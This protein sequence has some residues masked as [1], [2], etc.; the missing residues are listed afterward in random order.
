MQYPEIKRVQ[1]L[2]VH[3]LERTN[4]NTVQLVKHC[5]MLPSSHKYGIKPQMVR[6]PS[7]KRQHSTFSNTAIIILFY[8]VTR[9]AWKLYIIKIRGNNRVRK[10]S[11]GKSKRKLN[12]ENWRN[13]WYLYWTLKYQMER[14]SEYRNSHRNGRNALNPTSPCNNVINPRRRSQ[15]SW[16][17]DF[18]QTAHHNVLWPPVYPHHMQLLHH[19][20]G[21][22]TQFR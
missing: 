11:S 14:I 6:T 1:P 22:N 13:S 20:Y 7:Q 18:I 21:H 17:S 15:N 2:L 5:I 9:T 12:D 4:P 10:R 8:F 19:S 3:H 16:F